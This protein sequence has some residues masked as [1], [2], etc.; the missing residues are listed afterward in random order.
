MIQYSTLQYRKRFTVHQI[1]HV[2]AICRFL[3]GL[4]LSNNEILFNRSSCCTVYLWS[5][6]LCSLNVTVQCEIMQFPTTHRWSTILRKYWTQYSWIKTK[7]SDQSTAVNFFTLLSPSFL[8]KSVFNY[9]LKAIKI[10][11]NKVRSG[12]ISTIFLL[13]MKQK[14]KPGR[15]SITIFL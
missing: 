10:H 9:C 3:S 11:K 14:F 4:N 1:R 7:T 6:L 15:F 5:Q 2:L 8:F 13:F 12:I